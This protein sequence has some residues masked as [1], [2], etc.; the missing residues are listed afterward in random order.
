MTGRLF[1]FIYKDYYQRFFCD[2]VAE[3]DAPQ[4]YT[5]IA[6][7]RLY[8]YIYFFCLSNHVYLYEQTRYLKHID[9]YICQFY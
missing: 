6:Y 1:L 4:F 8:T 7:I 5:N 2:A 9:P 3:W